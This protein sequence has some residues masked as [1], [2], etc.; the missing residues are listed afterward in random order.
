CPLLDIRKGAD[1]TT[2]SSRLDGNG[3]ARHTYE[4]R[5]PLELVQ[6]RGEI[7]RA[8]A[9][10]DVPGPRG[11]V[12]AE[13]G[14]DPGGR[15]GD[16]RLDALEGVQRQAV[17]GPTVLVQGAAAA[18][19]LVADQDRHEQ[20]GGDRRGVAASVGGRLGARPGAGPGVC[21]GRD[22]AGCAG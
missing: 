21:R 15:T 18:V 12:A 6:L 4:F 17:V 14:G 7:E 11:D 3:L 8:D 19:D 2:S 16:H 13:R 10:D 5:D 20:R 22:S 9:A 1:T